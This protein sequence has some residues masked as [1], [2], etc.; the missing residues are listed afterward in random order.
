MIGCQ[1]ANM[2]VT[3]GQEDL[4]RTFEEGHGSVWSGA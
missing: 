3:E 2:E 4:G 1:F